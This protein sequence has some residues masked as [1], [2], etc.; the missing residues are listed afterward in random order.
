MA[1][2]SHDSGDFSRANLRAI[3]ARGQGN[4]AA[5]RA[6]AIK[7]GNTEGAAAVGFA[8]ALGAYRRVLYSEKFRQLD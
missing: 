6:Q 8:G 7:E 1:R 2:P 3:S 4:E 5:A